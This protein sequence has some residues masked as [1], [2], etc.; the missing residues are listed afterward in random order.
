MMKDILAEICCLKIIWLHLQ[1]LKT[2]GCYGWIATLQEF[3][4]MKVDEVIDPLN[5]IMLNFGI[6]RFDIK[7]F[8]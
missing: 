4:E 5:A 2:W 7:I 3:L 1:D 8:M 6:N